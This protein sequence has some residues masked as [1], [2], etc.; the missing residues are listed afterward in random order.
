MSLFSFFL[1][2]IWQILLGIYYGDSRAR[3][4]RYNYRQKQERPSGGVGG[5]IRDIIY[6]I[7]SKNRNRVKGGG[8]DRTGRVGAINK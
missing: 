2:V 5:A 6:K 3:L 1:Y 8:K 4:S 7:R